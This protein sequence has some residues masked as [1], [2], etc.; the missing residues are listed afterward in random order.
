[1]RRGTRAHLESVL[2]KLLLPIHKERAVLD[3]DVVSTN[4]D[5]A[6]DERLRE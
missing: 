6:L 2:L 3:L 5:D 1:M 4:S